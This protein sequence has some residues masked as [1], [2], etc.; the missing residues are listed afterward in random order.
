[1]RTYTIVR[2]NA[3]LPELTGR[4]FNPE[5]CAFTRETPFAPIDRYTWDTGYRC[6]ARAYVTKGRDSLNVLLCAK[7]ATIQTR[8]KEFNGEVWRDS[9]LEFFVQPRL[10]D[11]RYMN[12]ETNAAG[13]MLIGVG[14]N[15]R[16]RTHLE[17]MPENMDV[18]HSQHYGEWWAVSY[19]I[20]FALLEWIFG[21]IPEQEMRGNFY[22]VDESIHP[23]FATWNTIEWETPD[24]HRPECFGKLYL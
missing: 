9:C 14:S 13:V 21:K 3:P 19:R 23:H 12:I 7:E 16:N 11:S 22:S 1:M 4:E 2:E 20:P 24:F 5:T 17:K 18:R 10:D 15:R 6:E 8:A